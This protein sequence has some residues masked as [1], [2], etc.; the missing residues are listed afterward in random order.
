[1]RKKSNGTYEPDQN[2]TENEHLPSLG[3]GLSR[4]VQQW[5]H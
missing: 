2:E 1:M 5:S 3:D 4:D